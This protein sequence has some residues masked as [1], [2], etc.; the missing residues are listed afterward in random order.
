MSSKK[1][2]KKITATDDKKKKRIKKRN[3]I[4]KK[5]D[6]YD[7]LEQKSPEVRKAL[8][9]EQAYYR[10]SRDVAKNYIK[11]NQEEKE[12]LKLEF[13]S[14]EPKQETISSHPPSPK[15]TVP[16]PGSSSPDFDI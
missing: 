15:S 12:K 10:K 14:H 6:Y 13:Y 4:L 11:L 16:K 9:A 2:I 1:D 5:P 7:N 8:K 3:D